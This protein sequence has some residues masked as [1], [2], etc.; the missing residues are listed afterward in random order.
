M[1]GGYEFVVFS[2][3]PSDLETALRT[4]QF[5]EHELDFGNEDS[6][7]HRVLLKA[8]EY[9]IDPGHVYEERTDGGYRLVVTNTEKTRALLYRYRL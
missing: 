9:G 1:A 6:R 2:I 3:D 7:V 5:E 4:R 8:R